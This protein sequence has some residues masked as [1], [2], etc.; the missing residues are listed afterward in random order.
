MGGTCSIH[1]VR[2]NTIQNFSHIILSTGTTCFR[3]HMRFC[4]KIG[5]G[6]RSDM[7]SCLAC[8][9]FVVMCKDTGGPVPCCALASLGA[10]IC[11]AFTLL[12]S[13]SYDYT[14]T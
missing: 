6:F 1:V 13:S 12:S 3:R 10:G 4:Q 9:M 11:V 8:P 14:E 5:V 7:G 2:E